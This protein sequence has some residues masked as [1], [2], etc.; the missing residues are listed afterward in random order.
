MPAWGS[1][2]PGDDLGTWHLVH[3]IRYLPRVTAEDLAEMR[4]LN[5]RSLV[6]IEK[7]KA[8]ERFLAGEGGFGAGTAQVH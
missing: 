2:T 8:V 4:R 3:F 7:E 6:E 1:G 5:P